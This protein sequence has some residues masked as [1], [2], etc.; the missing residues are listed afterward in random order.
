MFN[1]ICIITTTLNLFCQHS[2]QPVA[3]KVDLDSLQHVSELPIPFVI[4]VSLDE[5]SDKIL[6]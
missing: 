3:D 2:M 5:I 6:P 1:C 4:L